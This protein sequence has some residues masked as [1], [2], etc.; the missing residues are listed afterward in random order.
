MFKKS[1][2]IFSFLIVSCVDS[3]SHTTGSY[4][5]YHAQHSDASENS[6]V[7]GAYRQNETLN[8]NDSNPDWVRGRVLSKPTL[9]KKNFLSKLNV[10]K[11]GPTKSQQALTNLTVKVSDICTIFNGHTTLE[12]DIMHRQLDGL[13][14]LFTEW[15]KVQKTN[16]DR[17]ALGAQM[18][19]LHKALFNSDQGIS[20]I[21][22]VID[23]NQADVKYSNKLSSDFIFLCQLKRI[24]EF[25]KASSQVLEIGGLEASVESIVKTLSTSISNMK[26]K[27]CAP[28]D[29]VGLITLQAKAKNLDKNFGTIDRLL[30]NPKTPFAKIMD[31]LIAITIGVGVG[32]LITD[33]VLGGE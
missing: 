7:V 29:I 9:A 6:N 16:A 33:L 22:G 24:V 5:N 30:K 13:E 19:K 26:A 32:L 27:D 20:I 14:P 4:L 2:S 12:D 17:I 11:S 1:V 8:V 3:G 28:S 23:R 21:K 18:G 10:F 25:Q 15:S 31:M